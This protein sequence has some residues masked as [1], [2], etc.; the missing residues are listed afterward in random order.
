MSPVNGDGMEI[1]MRKR[2]TLQGIDISH[3]EGKINFRHVRQSGIRIVYIKATQGTNYVDPDFERNY[4]EAYKE[5]LDVGF[6]HYVTATNTEEAREEAIFF[7]S[8]IKDKVQ[9]AR[10][11]M[12]F[13]TF[14]DLTTSEVRE[15][16]L[17]F[18]RTLEDEVKY[19]P[20]IYSDSSNASSR[21][22]D[23]QLVKYP[24]WIADYGVVRPDMENH[25]S[26]WSGWQY[27]DKGRVRGISGEVD[28]NRFRHDIL[29]S[30]PKI[31]STTY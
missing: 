23:Y 17:H 28:R 18:L 5:N 24:L 10:A 1:I 13:E 3:W 2:S 21:F 7:A 6:Y 19:R 20:V 12:D 15:I 30:E 4:R 16:A 14:G 8:K 22:D 27:T 25:W 11:A 9:Y 29:I 31:P 26:K